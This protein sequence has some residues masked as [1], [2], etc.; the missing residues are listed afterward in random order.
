MTERFSIL[1]VDDEVENVDMMTLILK[2]TYNVFGVT[3]ALKGLELLKKQKFHAIISDQRMP[4]MTGLEFLHQVRKTD[5]KII[6]VILTAYADL[7]MAI[8]AINNE[9]IQ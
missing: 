4:E 2:D 3:S 1:I 7:A 9:R 5:D 8:E 6:L